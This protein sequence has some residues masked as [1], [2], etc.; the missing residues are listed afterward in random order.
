[1][2]RRKGEKI[3]NE[4]SRAEWLALF[5]DP[6]IMTDLVMRMFDALY[7]AEGHEDRAKHIAELLGMEY[8][9]LNSAAGWAGMKIRALHA[10]KTEAAPAAE[11]AEAAP[12]DEAALLETEEC[13]E[14]ERAPWEYLFNGAEEQDGSYLWILKPEAAAAWRELTETADPLRGR[15]RQILSEDASAFGREGSLFEKKPRTT[16]EDIRAAIAAEEKFQRASLSEGP[17]CTV[18]GISRLSLLRAEPYG[19]AGRK[20]KGLLFCPTHAALFAAHLIS[21]SDKG[22]L[23]VSPLLTEEE[24][25]QLS[26]TEGAS[27]KN[28][29]SRRRMA[30]HRKLFT[31]NK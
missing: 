19:S 3:W 8:R 17:C 1:M 16:V 15:L 28:A 13:A 24:R 2:A 25:A 26:L 23:L 20:Q 18:C 27:A 29:F 10:A 7:H 4:V 6:E 14:P 5:A 12:A 31:E 30:Q 21:Y 11:S 22:A 9:A